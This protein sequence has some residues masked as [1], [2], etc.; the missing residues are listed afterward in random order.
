M[1]LI[2]IGV[3]TR[4]DS[5]KDFLL[6]LLCFFILPDHFVWSLTFLTPYIFLNVRFLYILSEYYEILK[7]FSEMQCP[8][9]IPT[10]FY[11]S[12]AILFICICNIHVD[13]DKYFYINRSALCVCNSFTINHIWYSYISFI[14]VILST[15]QTAGN[16][17]NL[18]YCYKEKEKRVIS[19]AHC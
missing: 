11:R 18:C 6:N 2:A 8:W 5:F 4:V 15:K 9:T 1:Y 13:T 17:G 16:Q 19:L 12:C 3:K 14:T 10:Y 7:F